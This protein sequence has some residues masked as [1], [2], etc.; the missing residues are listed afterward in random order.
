MAKVLI[1]DSV[2]FERLSL[3]DIFTKLGHEVVAEASNTNDLIKAYGS[4]SPDYVIMDIA[5]SDSEGISSLKTLLKKYPEAKV[6]VCTAMAQQVTVIES[7]NAGAKDF[8]VKPYQAN[9]IKQSIEKVL[10][11]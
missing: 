8:V 9:R 2:A 7:I 6:C 3:K 1:A 4:A 11:E 5:L 10:A